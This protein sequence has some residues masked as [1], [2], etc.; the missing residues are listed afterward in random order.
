MRVPSDASFSRTGRV[1][2]SKSA[3]EAYAQKKSGS[4]LNYESAR[5]SVRIR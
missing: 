3:A 1:F 4:V 2:L 5:G